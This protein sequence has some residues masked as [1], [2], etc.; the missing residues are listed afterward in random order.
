MDGRFLKEMVLE[1]FGMHKATLLLI[2]MVSTEDSGLFHVRA[3]ECVFPALCP[4]FCLIIDSCCAI[5]IISFL[6]GLPPLMI[7]C[8]SFFFFFFNHN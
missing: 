8:H 2:I 7:Y 4:C 6:D 5:F 3:L 1:L